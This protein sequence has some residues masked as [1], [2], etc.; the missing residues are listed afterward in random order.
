MGYKPT[1]SDHETTDILLGGRGV[2]FSITPIPHCCSRG[3]RKLPLSSSALF[4]RGRIV[5]RAPFI[6][7]ARLPP[8]IVPALGFYRKGGGCAGGKGELPPSCDL[9]RASYFLCAAKEANAY[10]R[11]LFACFLFGCS[12]LLFYVP[13]KMTKGKDEG[14]KTNVQ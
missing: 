2:E 4:F 10:S 1:T 6:F 8:M 5:Y 9:F 12:A 13:F 11:I 3:E 14:Y 7:I